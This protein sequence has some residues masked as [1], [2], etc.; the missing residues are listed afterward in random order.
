MHGQEA[1]VRNEAN[2]SRPKIFVDA[3]HEGAYSFV[4]W[5][6][7]GAERVNGLI[8][9]Q[10]DRTRYLMEYRM[11]LNKRQVDVSIRYNFRLD[12]RCARWRGQRETGT[13]EEKA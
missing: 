11:P 1:A 3:F 7:P 9:G 4:V 8:R 13:E 12:S 2:R 5:R 6:I 10:N